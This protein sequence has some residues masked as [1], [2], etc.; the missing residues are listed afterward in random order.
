MKLSISNI[1]WDLEEE[2]GIIRTLLQHGVQ[3]IEIAPTKIWG[4]PISCSEE[5]VDIY[6]SKWEAE[7]IGLHAMQSLL[8]GKPE[9]LLFSAEHIRN[10]LKKYLH[11]VMRLA[12]LMGIK[13]L[14]FGSPKNR[15]AGSLNI[16]EQ[17][18]IAIPFFYEIGEI[19]LENNLVFCIE[20]NPV[21][22]GCDF[23]T[24][25]AQ[26]I[27]IVNEVSHPGFRLHLDAAAMALNN[28]NYHESIEKSLPILS[29]FHISQPFLNLIG[30]DN[31]VDHKLIA[32]A[33]K[34]NQYAHTISIEM[35]NGLTSSNNESVI[36]ALDFVQRTYL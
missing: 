11:R 13:V 6:R 1:A 25:T 26:G 27:E 8:F 20:P 32:N 33:L 23:I 18:N 5:D 12:N 34:D 24:N 28:E 9:L 3:D 4:S 19:A 2:E 22:Y 17:L 35:K 36:S 16:V 21:Q 29:H 7:N 10:E 14:V 30:S 31:L 15:F